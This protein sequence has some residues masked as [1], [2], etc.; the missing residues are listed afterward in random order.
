MMPNEYKLISLNDL[1]PSTLT[2]PITK[3]PNTNVATLLNPVKKD[4]I[5]NITVNN[6]EH[7]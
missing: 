6:I 2:N 3:I 4:K 1:Y 7:V 5:K